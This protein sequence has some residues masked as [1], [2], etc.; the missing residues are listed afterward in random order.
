MANQRMRSYISLIRQF[1][2]RIVLF[3]SAIAARFGLN[4]TDLQALRLLHEGPMSAGSLGR[5]VG[6]T[7]PSMTALIDRLESAG[8]VARERGTQDRRRVT[9]HAIP[10]KL[11]EIDNYYEKQGAHMAKLL[12]KYSADEFKVIA[13][14]LEQSVLILSNEVKSLQDAK[15]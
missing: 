4:T 1:A 5:L 3:H 13:D 15:E 10:E 2:A 11:N 8:Y 9:V 12:S 6:L 14:F 7:G